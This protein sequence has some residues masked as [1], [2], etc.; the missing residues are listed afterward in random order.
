VSKCYLIKVTDRLDNPVLNNEFTTDCASCHMSTFERTNALNERVKPFLRNRSKILGPQ[1]AKLEMGTAK[2]FGAELNSFVNSELSTL[3]KPLENQHFRD[4]P[5][6]PL[7]MAY[8][9]I[10]N[11]LNDMYVTNQ[12]SY[13]QYSP[14]I[15]RG[16]A[17]ETSRAL[18]LLATK[19]LRPASMPSQCQPLVFDAC[20]NIVNESVA[21]GERYVR[22]DFE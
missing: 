10:N 9:N 18:S 14:I 22:T 8:Q 3:N 2:T 4:G 16:V 19:N 6:V 21:H 13:S 1:S 15:S 5:F 7:A 17:N 20:E 11:P 12:L